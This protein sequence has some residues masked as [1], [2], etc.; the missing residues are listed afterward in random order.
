MVCR[1]MTDSDRTGAGHAAGPAHL[2]APAST[3]RRLPAVSRRCCCV[4]D[5]SP[6]SLWNLGERVAIV[7]PTRGAVLC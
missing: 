1:P 3:G 7:A 6:V 4:L 5:T 2:D